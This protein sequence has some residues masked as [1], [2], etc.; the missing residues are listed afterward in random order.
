MN[1]KICTNPKCRTI[2]P[3]KK[4]HLCK[5]PTVELPTIP[6]HSIGIDGTACL[7]HKNANGYSLLVTTGSGTHSMLVR[8]PDLVHA[9]QLRLPYSSHVT[10]LMIMDALK[11]A[12]NLVKAKNTG[13]W[14]GWILYLLET[15]Q[16]YADSASFRNV[17][18]D[19][20]RDL[21]AVLLE[22]DEPPEVP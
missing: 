6:L 18:L 16:D 17:V 8:I 3:G 20:Q 12:S 7:T 9:A 14:A 15:L 10:G 13:F 5:A 1:A 4:C 19:L 22:D 21:A 2:Q 11:I